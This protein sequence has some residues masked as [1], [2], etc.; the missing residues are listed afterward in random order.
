MTAGSQ[1]LSPARLA[2]LRKAFREMLADPEFR[3]DAQRSQLPLATKTGEE[4]QK[5]VEDLFGVSPATLAAVRDLG[6]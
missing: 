6:K 3:A 4:M 5:E 2:L 1:G